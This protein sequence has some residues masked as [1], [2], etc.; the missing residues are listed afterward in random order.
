MDLKFSNSIPLL[1]NEVDRN[2]LSLSWH[3]LVL[4]GQKRLAKQPKTAN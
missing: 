4:G 1:G 2:K 3:F